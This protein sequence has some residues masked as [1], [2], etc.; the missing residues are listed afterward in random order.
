MFADDT[1]NMCSALVW[2]YHLLDICGDYAG[3]REI[4]FNCNKTTGVLFV[5]KYK[6]PAAWKVFLNCVHV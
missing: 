2:L 5:S 3:E 1:V 4:A 6:E